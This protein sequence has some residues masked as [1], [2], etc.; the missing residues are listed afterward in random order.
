MSM[1]ELIIKRRY[2]F[3]QDELRDKLGMEGEEI[4]QIG[5][6]SGRSSNDEEEG[7]SSDTD[8]YFIETEEKHLN[9]TVDVEKNKFTLRNK[10]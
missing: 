7:F 9:P 2:I 3:S 6:W 1:N 8:I 10:K 4:K 5:L